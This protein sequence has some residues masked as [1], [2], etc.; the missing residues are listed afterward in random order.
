MTFH[1]KKLLM[2]A[3]IAGLSISA[4]NGAKAGPPVDEIGSEAPVVLAA[5]PEPTAP[6]RTAT[7]RAQ[8]ARVRT[9]TTAT[10]DTAI[11]DTRAATSDSPVKAG[12]KDTLPLPIGETHPGDAETR[13][14]S[15]GAA[16]PLV[17]S[18]TPPL[19]VELVNGARPGERL[20]ADS[21]VVPGKTT[22]FDFYSKY[23]GP[24]VQ[25]APFLDELAKRNSGIVVRKVDIN[26]RGV[27]GID[28]A[29]P[30]ARQ[31]GLQ[32]IP[33]FKIYGADGKL[34]SEGDPAFQLI[35]GWFKEAGLME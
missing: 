30:V 20:S 9:D 24:C 35:L 25:I 32:S 22:I 18:D 3:A 7:Q 13:S 1:P 6:R 31:Y 28:W 33:H 16:P 34:Q 14:E 4:L 26:R 15:I 23:C 5:S 19:P 12:G 27:R 11:P 2:L 10:R 21:F 8:R 17:N 29:S